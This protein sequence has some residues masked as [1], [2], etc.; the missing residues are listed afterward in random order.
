MSKG[1]G[2]LWSLNLSLR[3]NE[4]WFKDLRPC[5]VSLLN[6][7]NVFQ[8]LIQ[9]RLDLVLTSSGLRVW[10]RT[11]LMTFLKKFMFQNISLT[12]P[13]ATDHFDTLGGGVRDVIEMFIKLLI[14]SYS[15]NLSHTS[16]APDPCTHSHRPTTCFHCLRPLRYGYSKFQTSHYK[17][18]TPNLLLLV[19]SGMDV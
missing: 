13:C 17:F 10:Y 2:H 9:C 7:L 16:K 1:L 12:R 19:K 4:L 18:I 8:L 6:S 14:G 11:E 5:D 15:C 3:L